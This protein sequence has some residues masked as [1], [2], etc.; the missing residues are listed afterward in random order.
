MNQL[1][2]PVRKPDRRVVTILLVFYA[3]A[4]LLV[5][6]SSRE[7]PASLTLLNRNIHKDND[8][9]CLAWV[10]TLPPEVPPA[11]PVDG[12]GEFPLK[13]WFNGKPLPMPG[14]ETWEVMNLGQGRYKH[15]GH[16]LLFS[17]PDGRDPRE[18]GNRL[19][20][21]FSKRPLGHLYPWSL[22]AFALLSSYFLLVLLFHVPRRR[23]IRRHVYLGIL[24]CL[25]AL[26]LVEILSRADLFHK[27]IPLNPPCKISTNLYS[28][29]FITQRSLLFSLPESPALG[30]DP[31]RESH[32]PARLLFKG[33]PLRPE[34][35]SLK[36]TLDKEGGRYSFLDASLYFR[37]PADPAAEVFSLY[38]IRYP[39]RVSWP[40][41]ALTGILLVL[42]AGLGNRILGSSMSS[43]AI[44]GGAAALLALG[45]LLLGLNA[46]GLFL[47][48]RGPE[49]SR[50]E[51]ILEKSWPRMPLDKALSLLKKQPDE[52]K[53]AY[54]KKAVDT[55][56][57]AMTA[58]FLDRGVW[59]YR[60]RIPPWENYLLT[61]LG[62]RH[63]FGRYLFLD[64]HKAL[65]RGIGLRAQP[66]L[67]LAGFLAENG[68]RAE[69]VKLR[70]YMLVR[71]EVR[72]GKFLLLD[73]LLGLHFDED[74]DRLL[75]NP[76]HAIDAYRRAAP[77][78][79]PEIRKRW[80]LYPLVS[81]EDK[82]YKIMEPKEFFGERRA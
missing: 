13:V 23:P 30:G 42:W 45:T 50:A 40:V 65:E 56:E 81:L 21:Q 75:Q 20:I 67:V 60:V 47:P 48:L 66:C 31:A 54:C 64:P 18:Y 61:V 2:G 69:I 57:K 33:K 7:R 53:E 43:L 36:E 41:L 58:Y 8:K 6:A 3:L 59:R 24:A 26:L 77:A 82:T 32:S 34:A 68:V 70:S 38:G 39:L 28:A 73:P 79:A 11:R 22:L 51:A 46:V 63:S 12:T 19:T 14:A 35:V 27:T 16:T 29:V 62:Q 1:L 4:G 71:A 55:V 44:R 15:Y 5:L 76:G 25:A 10:V 78:A 9:T 74:L 80:L 72:P 49:P 52:S 17:T 37:P